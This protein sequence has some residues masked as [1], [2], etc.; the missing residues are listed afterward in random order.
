MKKSTLIT[1]SIC[2]LCSCMQQTKQGEQIAV[3]VLVD[4]TD[5]HQ[6]Y[7]DA[8]TVLP[9]FGLEGNQNNKAVFKL[10]PITDRKLNPEASILLEEGKKTEQFNHRQDPLFRKRLIVQFYDSVK[11]VLRTFREEKEKAD[12]SLHNSEV[13]FMIARELTLLKEGQSKKRVLLIY[14]DLQENSDLV[15]V[16]HKKKHIKQ[17]DIATYFEKTNLLPEDLKNITV[18]VIYKAPTREADTNFM[19]LSAIYE[20]MIQKRGGRYIVSANNKTITP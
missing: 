7:P 16:Y 6:V 13:F 9:L 12:T 15:S 2:F 18:V 4:I 10:L 5:P 11:N 3:T 20:Q 1:A 14:S 19:K 8:K 17:R